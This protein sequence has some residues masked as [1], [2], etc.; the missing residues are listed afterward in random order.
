MTQPFLNIIY[1]IKAKNKIFFMLDL[2]L[3]QV[4]RLIIAFKYK[5]FMLNFTTN[6]KNSQLSKI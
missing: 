2:L 1:L 4:S 3:L 5:T 6:N